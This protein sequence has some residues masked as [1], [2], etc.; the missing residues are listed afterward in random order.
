VA[1]A[2]CWR[3]GRKL[4]E[5]EAAPGVAVPAGLAIRLPCSRCHAMNH[6]LL[7]KLFGLAVHLDETM[8]RNG[9]RLVSRAT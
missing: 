6:V 1:D 9:G 3:C 5:S 7:R 8:P 2:N 4:F